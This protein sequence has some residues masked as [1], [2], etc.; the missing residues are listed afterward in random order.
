MRILKLL[1]ASA[2]LFGLAFVA[3]AQASEEGGEPVAELAADPM[4]PAQPALA[5]TAGSGAAASDPAPG[6]AAAAADASESAA[7]PEGGIV[8]LATPTP[9][10]DSPP[11]APDAMD[12]AATKASEKTATVLGE[13]G[14][15]AE[16]R[17]GRIHV[18]VRGDT[19]WD[20]S[21]AYLGTPW[22]WPSIW[23]D[24][25]NIE[26]PHRINPGDH[27]WITDSEMRLLSPAEAEA[28][29]AAGPPGLDDPPAAQS[30]LLPAELDPAPLGGEVVPAEQLYRRVSVREWLGLIS[31]EDLEAA[32]SIVQRVPDQV[33]LGQLDQVYIG[34][35]EG[36]VAVGDQFDIIRKQEA[37]EDPETGR[38]LGYHVAAM[39]WLEVVEVHGESALATI[40]LSTE[41]VWKGDR[42]IPRRPETMDIAIRQ[43]PEDVEGMIAFFPHKR[44]VIGPMD[45]VYLNRGTLDGLE[46]GSP[47]E[48]VRGGERVDEP[49]RGSQVEIPRRVVAQL[50]VVDSQP[51]TSVALVAHTETD[52]LVGDAFRGAAH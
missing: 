23:K 42:V 36:D 40:R 50:L 2:L 27:I 34:L 22:V 39:G 3:T 29:L 13:I 30:E 51:E 6:D 35:G 20:I 15:D 32:A 49:V 1:V 18:V 28:M 12:G 16:G 7:K 45:F 46:A 25:R 10:D 11:A 19:L 9:P 48:V 31:A 26:N 47:L 38:F 44:V 4:D 21:D 14:Y 37:V 43:S 33:M 41:D 5:E 8:V 24:N 17:Q 52:L